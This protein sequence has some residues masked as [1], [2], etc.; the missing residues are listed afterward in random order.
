MLRNAL[1]A[2]GEGGQ[3]LLAFCK[4][5]PLFFQLFLNFRH[6]LLGLLNLGG[7][8]AAAILLTLEFFLN[9]GNVGAVIVHISLQ[10]RHLT[11]QLLVGGT[12][13]IGF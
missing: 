4:L 6:P 12:E 5:R 9:P 3:L 7:N 13:H 8:A 2:G 11:I 1:S 10:N